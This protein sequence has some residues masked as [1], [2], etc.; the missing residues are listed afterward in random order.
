[1]GY[2]EI[3]KEIMITNNLSQESLAKILSVN[4]TTIGQWLHGKKKPSYDSILSIYKN[5]EITPN[6]VFGLND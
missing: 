6:E 2:Q 5:F 4:Q 1:M 3:I